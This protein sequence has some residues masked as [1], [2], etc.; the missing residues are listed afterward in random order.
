MPATPTLTPAQ[1]LAQDVN[2]YVRHKP[3]APPVSPVSPVVLDEQQQVNEYVNEE[4]HGAE[5]A[6]A[7][8][9]EIEQPASAPEEDK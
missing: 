1:Q 2:D 8:V 6:A 7:P 3:P 9:P 5:E 4:R